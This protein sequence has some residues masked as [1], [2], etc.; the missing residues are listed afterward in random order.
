MPGCVAGLA[1][2]VLSMAAF[3]FLLIPNIF[4]QNA[5]AAETYFMLAV[6]SLTG[7]VYYW[8]VFRRDTQNR[9]GKSTVMWIMMLVLLFLSVNLWI[10][11]DTQN[12]SAGLE[13]EGLSALLTRNSII[14]VG[15]MAVMI[16]VIFSLFSTMLRREH[17]MERERILAEEGG[18]VSVTLLQTGL[19]SGRPENSGLRSGSYEL[20]VKDNGIGMSP[21]FAER[22]FEAFERERTSTVSNIQGTGL[23]MA[24]T[25]GII[26]LM[27]GTIRVDTAPGAGTEVII[28]LEFELVSE[29]LVI[30]ASPDGKERT[31]VSGCDFGRTR[32][33]LVEDNEIN[34]EIATTI[35]SETGFM[36]ETAVNGK[37]AV[38]MVAASKP[39]HF[40]LVLMDVQMPVMD[41][42]EATRA[43]RALDNPAVA[44]IPIVAMT[45]NAFTEDIQAAKNAGM[46]AHIAKPIDISGMIATITEVLDG[47]KK[48]GGQM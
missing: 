33:L 28:D 48:N 20:R 34:L 24:I 17:R 44:N 19:S 45:A 9:F 7:I 46:N 25:K 6:W 43:I 42:Y 41:G 47:Q 2:M 29:E 37:E 35:L 38:D 26:D 22:V 12:R 14:E 40:D 16:L 4:F 36:L 21:E 11:M 1:G 3:I 27:G 32:L 5:L 18:R 13:G 31:D 15:L 10:A 8:F 30:E 23:G 39:G